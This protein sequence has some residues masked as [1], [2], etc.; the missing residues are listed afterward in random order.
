MGQVTAVVLDQ[1]QREPQLAEAGFGLDPAAEAVGDPERVVDAAVPG[2]DVG[3]DDPDAAQGQ[4]AGGQR[5][6]PEAVPGPH[7][8]PG[9]ERL[10][11]R[12]DRQV[13]RLQGRRLP[14]GHRP[15]TATNRGIRR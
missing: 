8:D 10:A 13:D 2:P 5:E 3:L 15:I 14:A 1:D 12:V 9:G 4:G 7:P 6:E 11:G